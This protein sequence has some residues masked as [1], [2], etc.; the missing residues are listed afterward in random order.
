MEHA[1]DQ[2]SATLE[3]GPTQMT[4]DG[5]ARGAGATVLEPWLRAQS[6]NTQRHAAA[7]RPFQRSEFGTGA[8]APSEAHIG[9]ANS[10]IEQLR[11]S[12][13]RIS[14]YTADAAGEATRQPTT[15]NLE[16][17]LRR[18]DRAH[19]W[20][21]A[22]ERIWDFYFELFGQRQSRYGDWLL[23]CDRI[24]LDCYRSVYAG[25]PVARSIP[26]PTPFSYMRTG[27]SPATFRRGIPL[28][29]LG[30]QINPFPLIQL[31]YH[32]LVNPWTL[33]AV[34]HEVS[35]NIH[36]DVGLERAI[37]EAIGRQ[38]LRAG[39]PKGIAS[40]WQR[41]NREL[42]ADLCG[43]LLG[44]PAI[45][46]SLMDV[47]GRSLGLT[48]AYDPD[49]VHPT[50]YLRTLVSV[51]LLERMGFS[52][53]ARRYRH[54]WT[55]LYAR[56]GSGSM[57]RQLLESSDRVIPL[58]VDTV[59]FQNYPAL[60]NRS[61]AQVIRFGAKEQQ[62]TEETAR[63]LAAGRDPGVI[64]ERFLIGAARVGLDR[65]FARPHVI[66]DNFYRILARR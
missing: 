51:E 57:P 41:W 2:Q 16:R 21:Q 49:G 9:A 47:V 20:V 25:M 14:R 18:K 62:V 31:P 61:L 40:I 50:P 7:L 66:A 17:I 3:H 46:A 43:L 39:L 12:L 53:E 5:R 13:L 23:S 59:C 45:V 52:A 27:F 64:P 58:V 56:P 32:R 34:L 65:R 37:P 15:A 19:R 22:I 4:E 6:I 38:L 42:F 10:L 36:N 60:G 26:S 63:R 8:S 29:R 33:G 30:R 1:M 11:M 28:Q 55:R 35:H 44:G 24:A 48:L 54:A